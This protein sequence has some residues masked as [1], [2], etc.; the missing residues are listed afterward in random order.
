VEL[1]V[2]DP[3]ANAAEVHHEYNLD[4]I[5]D[6]KKLNETYHAVI[7]AV[8]HQEFINKNWRNKLIENGVLYDVKGVLNINTIDSRL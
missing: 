1:D 3:F 4:L 2:L 7:L 8:A 6:E 5:T